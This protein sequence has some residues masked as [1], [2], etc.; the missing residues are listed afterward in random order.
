MLQHSG[1]VEWIVPQRILMVLGDKSREADI[2]L[3]QVVGAH[4]FLRPRMG[5]RQRRKQNSGEHCNHG[6][7]HQQFD[8]GEC[9]TS[10]VGYGFA[11]ESHQPSSAMHEF[12]LGLGT[13]MP[14]EAS[15]SNRTMNHPHGL[16]QAS[17][18]QSRSFAVPRHTREGYYTFIASALDWIRRNSWQKHSAPPVIHFLPLLRMSE[19]MQYSSRLLSSPFAYRTAGIH[20][21]HWVGADWVAAFGRRLPNLRNLL[22][23]GLAAGAGTSVAQDLPPRRRLSPATAFP[24]PDRSRRRHSGFG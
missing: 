4:Q 16:L 18:G 22:R 6:D 5:R 21:A 3:A 11:G 24:L 23:I 20:L 12:L 19:S 1:P 10:R 8:Q 9:G 13:N 15:K 17:R 2:E 14:T 7:Y